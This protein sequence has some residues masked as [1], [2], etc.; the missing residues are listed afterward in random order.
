MTSPFLLCTARGHEVD[1]L[2][3]REG[4]WNM[5][6][7][8]YDLSLTDTFSREKKAPMWEWLLLPRDEYLPAGL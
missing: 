6:Q 4:K 1:F 2:I 8:C 5:I 3:N 7:V